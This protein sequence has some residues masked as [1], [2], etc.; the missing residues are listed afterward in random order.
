MS[1][2][3]AHH[4]ILSPLA[5]V[6]TNAYWLPV[7][8]TDD[9]IDAT[10]SSIK[11][12]GISLVRIWAFNGQSLRFLTYK[13]ICSINILLDVQS[14]PVNGTWFQL[15]SNGTATINN[16]TN[17]L[18]KLDTVVQLAEKH[19]L[20]LQLALT[21]NWNPVNNATAGATNGTLNRN[22]LSN[23]YGQQFINCLAFELKETVQEG[24]MHTS[25]SSV[26]T[27]NTMISI[28]TKR[29]LMPS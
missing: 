4:T 11:A 15:I 24:W 9:D 8:N 2:E 1:A 20:F 28:Q 26:P 29:F 7:L 21:N 12:A 18:Q 17:G 25:E 5:F 10:L 23:D 6:G 14:I 16:G 22:V 27:S 13:T 3:G 19:G